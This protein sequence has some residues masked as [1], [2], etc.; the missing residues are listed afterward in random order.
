ML[1]GFSSQTDLPL[2]VCYE[3][4]LCWWTHSGRCEVYTPETH[5]WGEQMPCTIS[6]LIRGA[7]QPRRRL[8]SALEHFLVTPSRPS[9][10]TG[11]AYLISTSSNS[12]A[13]LGP[14]GG[15]S[16]R[17]LHT[18]W[19]LVLWL[20]SNFPERPVVRTASQG[21]GTWILLIFQVPSLNQG[22]KCL[23]EYLT[24]FPFTD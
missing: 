12:L 9:L 13:G 7:S 21:P 6:E 1:E 15:A 24:E 18:S 4:H 20:P 16:P 2:G 14:L 22:P 17:P 5:L 3:P 10:S 23:T 8:N 19:D 11:T